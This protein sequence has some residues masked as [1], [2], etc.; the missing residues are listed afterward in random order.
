MYSRVPIRQD[1]SQC[2]VFVRLWKETNAFA[3]Q[4]LHCILQNLVFVDVSLTEEE[5]EEEKCICQIKLKYKPLV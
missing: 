4:I 2:L 5:Q 1:T 3:I